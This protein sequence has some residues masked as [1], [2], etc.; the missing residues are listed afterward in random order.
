M[1]FIDKFKAI[2]E[3]KKRVSI[4]TFFVVKVKHCGNLLS[5]STAHELGLVILHLNTVTSQEASLDH[6]L[7]KNV[8]VFTGSAS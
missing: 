1:D 3:T 5:L 2:I 6:I 7:Q 8:T 4:V